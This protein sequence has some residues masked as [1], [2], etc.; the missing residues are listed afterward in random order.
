[1]FTRVDW[2]ARIKHGTIFHIPSLRRDNKRR[3]RYIAH[4]DVTRVNSNIS[5]TYRSNNVKKLSSRRARTAKYQKRRTPPPPMKDDDG[6]EPRNIIA[7]ERHNR[8]PRLKRSAKNDRN[9]SIC[10]AREYL[11]PPAVRVVINIAA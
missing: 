5:G 7:L 4:E 2:R 10:R 3:K 8:K 1:M 6:D 11:I 9:S